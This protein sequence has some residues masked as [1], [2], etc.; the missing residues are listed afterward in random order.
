MTI[1]IPRNRPC[2]LPSL[3]PPAPFGP[4]MLGQLRFAA[5]L[6]TARLGSLP[7]VLRALHDPLALVLS[8]RTQECQDAL[9]HGASQIQVGLVEHLHQGTTGG[10]A[11]ND[12]DAVE[13][14]SR[15]P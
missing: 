7:A 6:N 5:K 10:N 2:R 1:E 12:L 15:C 4:L 13:H 11:L 8:K 14:R 9:A 3:E